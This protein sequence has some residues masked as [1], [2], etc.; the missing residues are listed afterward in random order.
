MDLDSLSVEP[1]VHDLEAES[2]ARDFGF[3][4]K[5]SLGSERNPDAL[6]C[7]IG[8]RFLGFRAL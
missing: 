6:A 8:T 2:K 5:K 4:S 3:Q 7:F 1:G